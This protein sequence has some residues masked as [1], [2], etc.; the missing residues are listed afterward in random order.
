MCWSEEPRSA[1]YS[2]R[3]VSPHSPKTTSTPCARS[4]S[5]TAWAPVSVAT[6]VSTGLFT[7]AVILARHECRRPAEAGARRALRRSRFALRRRLGRGGADFRSAGD[8]GHGDVGAAN[9]GGAGRRLEPLRDAEG[10]LP[11]AAGADARHTGGAAHARPDGA[12]C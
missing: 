7:A 4:I 8:E 12:V 3:L 2:G 9:S 11:R 6:R 10:R 1:S 5:T